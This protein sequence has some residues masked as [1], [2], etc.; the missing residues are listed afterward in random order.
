MHS[1]SRLRS[2]AALTALVGA[3]ATPLVAQATGTVRGAVLDA[4]DSSPLVNALVIVRAIADTSRVV[5]AQVAPTGA[6]IV[7]GLRAGTYAVRA[8]AIGFAPNVKTVSITDAIP[9]VDIGVVPLER[10]AVELKG[11]EVNDAAATVM[12][13]PDRNAY[14]AKDVAPGAANASE[15]LEQT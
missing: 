1:T 7:R 9:V 4:K 6:F 13:E 14:R 3:I 10:L 15:V 8:A 5:R 12:I 11:V 2:L